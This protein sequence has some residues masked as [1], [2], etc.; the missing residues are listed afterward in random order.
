M[1]RTKGTMGKT[2]ANS[3]KAARAAGRVLA[4]DTSVYDR[5]AVEAAAEEFTECA[6]VRAGGEGAVAV[7]FS[8]TDEEEEE[9]LNLALLRTIEE[10]RR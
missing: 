10:K 9:F 5:H 2:A 8:G 4:L 6:R 1:G 7:E 3:G